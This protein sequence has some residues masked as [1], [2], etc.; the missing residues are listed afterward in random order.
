[1]VKKRSKQLVFHDWPSGFHGARIFKENR[2]VKLAEIMPWDLI[3]KKYIEDS[4]L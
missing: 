4:V 3:E 1:M 2:W